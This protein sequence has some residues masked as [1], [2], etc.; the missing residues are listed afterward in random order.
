MQDDIQVSMPNHAFMAG[1]FERRG[2]L[3]QRKPGELHPFVDPDGYK[4]SLA[5]FLTKAQEKLVREQR[6]DAADPVA[7]LIKLLTPLVESY[8]SKE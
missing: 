4:A 1:I 3:E 7:T 5:L 8:R 2:A 6:G